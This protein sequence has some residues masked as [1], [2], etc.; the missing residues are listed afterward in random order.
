[1]RYYEPCIMG[2]RF[3]IS[4]IKNKI[5]LRVLEEAKSSRSP[6]RVLVGKRPQ[7][8]RLRLPRLRLTDEKDC[9]KFKIFGEHSRAGAVP[10][11]RYSREPICRAAP[12]CQSANPAAP[13]KPASTAPKRSQGGPAAWTSGGQRRRRGSVR[14]LSPPAAAFSILTT[15]RQSIAKFGFQNLATKS[16]QTLG[17]LRKSFHDNHS[18]M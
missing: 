5:G 18:Q 14:A 4:Q 15:L 9:R 8:R 1:M 10:S 17:E 3:I 12:I 6:V 13:T 16:W 2:M 11:S 7:Y